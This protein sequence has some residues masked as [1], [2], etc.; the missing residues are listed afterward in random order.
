MSMPVVCATMLSAICAPQ[1]RREESCIQKVNLSNY[2]LSQK[3]DS[4]NGAVLSERGDLHGAEKLST[5]D[6]SDVFAKI[7]EDLAEDAF[8]C[9]VLCNSESSGQTSGDD[10]ILECADCGFGISKNQTDSHQIE[11]HDLKVI[12]PAGAERANPHEFEMKLRCAA[13]SVLV[14]GKG[15]E[16]TVPESEGLESYSFHLQ[17]V[18]RTRGHWLL[19]YGAWEDHGSGRQVA[20]IRVGLGQVGALDKDY[21][22]AV[23]VKC[24]APAIRLNNPKRGLLGDS[25]RLIMKMKGGFIDRKSAKWE[26]RGK[27]SKSSLEVVGSNPCDSQRVLVG[28][29]D[30]ASKGIRKHKPM[31]KFT[32]NFPKSRNDLLHYHPKWKTWPG[33]IEV[34]G[35]DND[36][37]NGTYTKL[38]CQHTAVHSALWRRAATVDS[39]ALYLYIRPDVMRSD[40]DVAV[41]STTPSYRDRMEICELKDWIPENALVEKTHTTDAKFLKWHA[42]EELTLEVPQPSMI[43][44]KSD[45]LFHDRIS[46]D[47]QDSDPPI[48]CEMSGLSNEV[49]KSMLRH[50]NDGIAGKNVD[51]GV[52]VPIDLVGKMGSRNAKQMS[53]LAA[54]SLLKYAA[55]GRLPLDVLKWYNLEHPEECAFGLSE[56]NFPS[57]PLEKW[58]VTESTKK[59]KKVVKYEREFD[60][61]ESNEFYH[62]S[63]PS[64]TFILRYHGFAFSSDLLVTLKS[65][66]RNFYNVHRRS[67]QAWTNPTASLSSA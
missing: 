41:I 38:S 36:L 42:A 3:Y 23:Y 53:I 6:F 2:K 64:P 19:T 60:A 4:A 14:L 43:T 65:T 40:L 20:E 37:V 5:E 28:L 47:M 8:K 52:I 61:E 27:P 62:V 66:C 31:K 58:K 44:E 34:S 67:R 48:L 32:K 13:P 18:D 29:N 9:S 35:D 45:T 54:P 63:V 7:A 15:W 39:P 10:E 59:G 11:S 21:G 26:I 46:K 16:D 56:V 24:F 22:L 57:R 50:S 51:D 49:M 12:I 1:L 55:E 17:R 25:A 30:D 33:T